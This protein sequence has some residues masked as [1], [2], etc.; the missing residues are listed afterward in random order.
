MLS[1][2]MSLHIKDR[3]IHSENYVKKKKDSLKMDY[4]DIQKTFGSLMFSVESKGNIGKERV[5]KIITEI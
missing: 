2:K 1:N 3:T 4:T 5:N